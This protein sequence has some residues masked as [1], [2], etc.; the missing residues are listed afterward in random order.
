[1]VA[2]ISAVRIFWVENVRNFGADYPANF[3]DGSIKLY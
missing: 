2:L 1:M 3:T